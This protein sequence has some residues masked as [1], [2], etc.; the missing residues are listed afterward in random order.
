M[1][2]YTNIHTLYILV[3]EQIYTY[4]HTL[5]MHVNEH[6]YTHSYII[7]TCKHFHNHKNK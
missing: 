6:I 5:Y 2:I 3:N 1:N 7:H 4:I